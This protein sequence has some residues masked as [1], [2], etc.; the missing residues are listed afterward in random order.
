MNTETSAAP[1][2]QSNPFE[3]IKPAFNAFKLCWPT[4]ISLIFSAIGAA[5]LLIL[6]FAIVNYTGAG[7]IANVILFLAGIPLTLY[8]LMYVS[9]AVTR[10]MLSAV[11]GEKI[12]FNASLPPAWTD[13]LKLFVTQLLVILLT[14]FGFLLLIVP[15]IFALAFW[16]FA[17]TVTVDTGEWGWAALVKSR[18]IVRGRLWDVIGAYFMPSAVGIISII[19]LIGSLVYFVFAVLI[20]PYMVVRYE[21]ILELKAQPEWQSMPVSSWNYAALIV[22]LIAIGYSNYTS[23]RDMQKSPVPVEINHKAF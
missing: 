15:G 9:W 18:E 13:P 22:G 2:Y 4:V 11:R 8:L 3:L 16:S 20:A 1:A 12:G 14:V 7:P 6:L 21:T 5:V 17:P 10:S 19:P 23:Y